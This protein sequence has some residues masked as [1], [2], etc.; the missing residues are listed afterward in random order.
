MM[1]WT[2]AEYGKAMRIQRSGGSVSQEGPDPIYPAYVVGDSDTGVEDIW[3]AAVTKP[4]STPDQ[5]FFRQLLL[6]AAVPTPVPVV[7]FDPMTRGGGGGAAQI[8]E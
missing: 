5:N 1:S 2:D 8:R 3:V 4:K 7:R 6:N